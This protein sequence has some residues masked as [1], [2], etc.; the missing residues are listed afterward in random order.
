MYAKQKGLTD[1][2][3]ASTGRP[4]K[5]YGLMYIPHKTLIDKDG[6]VV[7]NFEMKLPDDLDSLLA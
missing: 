7:K 6:K 3:L 4:G 2:A 1:A 5:E